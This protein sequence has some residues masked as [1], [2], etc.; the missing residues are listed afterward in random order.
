M[1]E[2]GKG[3]WAF[4]GLF[5]LAV[6]LDYRKKRAS[7]GSHLGE[8]GEGY[9]VKP[10]PKTYDPH[11]ATV[12]LEARKAAPIA[13]SGSLRKF[14]QSAID[15]ESQQQKMAQEQSGIAAAIREKEKALAQ[16]RAMM[17]QARS[18]LER[19]LQQDSL[20]DT[21][22]WADRRIREEQEAFEK[23]KYK[24]RLD[25]AYRQALA[26]AKEVFK[27]RF[28]LYVKHRRDA[29]VAVSKIKLALLEAGDDEV[30]TSEGSIPK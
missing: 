8:N 7:M 9:A 24:R 29:D 18:D 4:A 23:S 26:A 28:N 25:Q 3:I 14:N 16:H 5:A 17:A 10:K 19:R 12:I 6:Y 13:V 30:L 27:D 22:V 1:K 21:E 20:R 2:K 15:L 11:V